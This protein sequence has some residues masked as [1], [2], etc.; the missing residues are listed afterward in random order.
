MEAMVALE[1]RQMETHLAL[2]AVAQLVVAG[3]S[4]R[5]RQAMLVVLVVM[6]FSTP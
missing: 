5:L 2:V 4:L 3:P 1:P 6:G